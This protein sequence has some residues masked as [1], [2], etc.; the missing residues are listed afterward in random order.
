M[1]RAL[2]TCIAWVVTV[3][4]SAA[5]AEPQ[6]APPADLPT[7]WIAV[8]DDGWSVFRPSPDSRLI[9]VSSSQG[10]DETGQVYAP[11]DA[12]VGDDPFRPDGPLH[13]FGTLEAAME[14]ARQDH[15]DW[16][17]L[18]R[19]DVWR[20]AKLSLRSGRSA[21]EPSLVAVYG[22]GDRRARIQGRR[23]QV[24]IGGPNAGVLHAAIVS[25]E[26][27]CDFVD[28]DSPQYGVDEK[29]EDREKNK[30][31]A[32]MGI[33]CGRRGP[34]E[35]VLVEDCL[36][37]FCHMSCVAFERSP[38]RNVVFR[39]NLVLDHYPVH[40]HT[41]GLWGSRCSI[42]LEENILDHNG[43]LLQRSEA[44]R[45]RPGQAIP[46]SHNT[47]YCDCHNTVFR[48]NMFLRA[49]SIGNKW[50]ANHGPGSV[51][52]ILIDNNLYVDG[53]IGISMGGNRPAPLRW[54]NVAVTNNVMLDIGR[55]R[56]TGRRLAWYL[57][58]SDWD[59]GLVAN[60]LFAH[61]P[62]EEITNV[63]AIHV[64]SIDGKG[65]YQGKGV[66]CRNVVVRDNVVHG[67][68]SGRPV[69]VA[70]GGPKYQ[71]IVFA[72]NLLQLPG[73]AQPL[74]DVGDPAGLGFNANCY[75]S[76]GAPDA[77]FE[78]GPR[79]REQSLG[80][81]QWTRR[82]GEPDARFRRADFPDPDRS[83]ETYMKSLGKEAS[84][85]AFIAEVRTQSKTNWRPEFTA[86][87]VNRWV[88]EGFGT[89]WEPPPE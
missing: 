82:A 65:T 57:D 39:R 3:A 56:P 38:M 12:A 81:E 76:D 25:V 68:R 2:W 86:E 83:I 88:R 59:G 15:P 62:R 64:G 14:H 60:N 85:D 30:T 18:R 37:R 71:G 6:I 31:Y 32:G 77:L 36:L 74:V 63:Y 16:V 11:G 87:A 89:R 7:R 27:Y 58:V 21:A 51:H 66:H 78:V 20:E 73:L 33:F 43:W 53:E 5:A 34:M 67:L 10:S 41:M 26:L 13:A 84:I 72:D 19:G 24:R 61:Q 45:G 47:Y 69:L 52:D 42:L 50:T 22:P 17:L 80:L 48:N 54:K 70:E 29:T 8:D 49:A 46:L 44:N 55:S 79:R 1:R 23:A 35:N 4:V 40:G 9:Y 75:Y 28:P